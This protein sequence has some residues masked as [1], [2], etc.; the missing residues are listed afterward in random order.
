M[1][2][3]LNGEEMNYLK[4]LD[5]EKCLTAVDLTPLTWGNGFQWEC[6]FSNRDFGM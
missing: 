4:R 5:L 1:S 6:E 3:D 2:N